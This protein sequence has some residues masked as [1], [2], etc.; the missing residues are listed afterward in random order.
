MFICDI[1]ISYIYLFCDAWY[2]TMI[3]HGVHHR[4]LTMLCAL[5]MVITYMSTM[6]MATDMYCGADDCYAVLEISRTVR[7]FPAFLRIHPCD[8]SLHMISL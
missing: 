1:S 6:V 2:R 8:F 4:Y 3:N 5:L 7:T